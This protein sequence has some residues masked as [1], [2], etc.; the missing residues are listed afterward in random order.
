MTSTLYMAERE[1]DSFQRHCRL[2]KIL[3]NSS[4]HIFDVGANIGQSLSRYREYFPNCFITSFE[5]NPEIFS[6]LEK[7]WGEVSGI[8]LNPIALANSVGHASF[9]AT[10]VS[11]VSSLLEP[12]DRMMKLSSEHKY[13]Y[14]M[15]DVPTLTLDHYCQVNN[16]NKIDI[17]KLDVQGFELNVLRGAEI[18]LQEGKVTMIY[19][20]VT[21]AETYMN[22]TGFIDLVSYLNKFN[23]E[24]WDIGSFL[25]TRNDRLWAAN[26][27]FLHTSAASFIE[28]KQTHNK[29]ISNDPI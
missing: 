18:L 26:L 7:N 23:Y 25:Y 24:I 27:T 22:Q 28:T 5:P 10:R 8:T 4:M 16:I 1:E 3:T 2:S 17:L 12:T 9:Y 21:F 19:S 20:E 29:E 11:E 13:D 15:I 6:L 14:K